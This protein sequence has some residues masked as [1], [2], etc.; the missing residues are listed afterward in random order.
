MKRGTRKRGA[1]HNI[2]A[3]SPGRNWAERVTWPSVCRRH[4]S[5]VRG[6]PPFLANSLVMG[7]LRFGMDG[8][9]RLQASY[10]LS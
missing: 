6:V 5:R 4:R 9:V 10:W 2:D 3:A 8:H 7:R 1:V